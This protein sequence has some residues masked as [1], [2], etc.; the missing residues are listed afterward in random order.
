MTGETKKLFVFFFLLTGLET[1]KKER[2][3]GIN[4]D[5]SDGTSKPGEQSNL[6]AVGD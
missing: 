6:K 5:E 3:E 4:I 1:K 2:I